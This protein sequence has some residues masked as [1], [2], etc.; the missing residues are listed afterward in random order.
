MI[1]WI[2][3]GSTPSLHPLDDPLVGGLRGTTT[4]P[5]T[6]AAAEW[7]WAAV[8]GAM[9]ETVRS[10]QTL[11]RPTF[12]L[13]TANPVPSGS[14]GP[15]TSSAPLRQVMRGAPALS[16]AATLGTTRNAR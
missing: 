10:Q 4:G 3:T 7:M 9:S 5:A 8:A 1:A 14:P 16:E 13:I 2:R 12:N 15:G 11:M 6:P